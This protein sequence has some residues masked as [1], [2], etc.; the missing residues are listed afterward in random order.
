M[1]VYELNPIEVDLKMWNSRLL[2][3]KFQKVPN[4]Y[5]G[6]QTRNTELVTV[7][8]KNADSNYEITLLFIHMRNLENLQST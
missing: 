2:E 4:S 6:F 5:G 8:K 1:L 3:D 7:Q